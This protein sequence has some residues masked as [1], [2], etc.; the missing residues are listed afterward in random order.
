MC[1]QKAMAN[2][3]FDE[4][5]G[6]YDIDT[7]TIRTVDQAVVDYFDKKI[8]ISV[9]GGEETRNKVPII[10]ASPER[11]KAVREGDGYRDD[12]G[13]LIL[14][15][16]SVRRANMERT[17][18]FGGMASEQPFITVSKK[19]SNRTRYDQNLLAAR[20]KNNGFPEPGKN[21]AIV[22]E[23]LTIPFPDFFTV[24]Y[25]ITIWVQYQSQM[26][27]ILE[28]IFYSYDLLDSF[29]MPVDYDRT[30]PDRGHGYYFVGFRDQ[31]VVPQSNVE[32]FTDQERIIKYSYTIKVPVYLILAPP[33]DPLA[34]G[35]DKGTFG[36]TGAPVV[37]QQQ[38]A[39]QILLNE[40]LAD[41]DKTKK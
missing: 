17:R 31:D 22:Y 11:W 29:T 9:D 15:L 23:Y 39:F 12:N 19:V 14:P 35:F 16:I 24:Y 38:S 2:N 8:A 13:T 1:L 27:E 30:M 26:N 25:D 37:Y 21:E 7:V 18:G 33:D 6:R 4:K 36:A 10:F 5:T 41:F 20:E 28:K 40:T 3:A 32:E 34:Y